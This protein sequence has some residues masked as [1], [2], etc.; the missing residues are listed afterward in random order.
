M[1]SNSDSPL[2]LL[3]QCASLAVSVIGLMAFL[4]LNTKLYCQLSAKA[5][6]VEDHQGDHHQAPACFNAGK[7]SFFVHDSISEYQS[8]PGEAWSGLGPRFE[9]TSGG[10]YGVLRPTHQSSLYTYR[11]HTST[12]S[13]D[14]GKCC[15]NTSH[16]DGYMMALRCSTT[17]GHN[18]L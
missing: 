10:K 7:H 11:P 3:I 16:E 15:F 17:Y 5:S 13:T 8:I 18:S 6:S 9:T 14:L 2:S 12:F 4:T 1:I